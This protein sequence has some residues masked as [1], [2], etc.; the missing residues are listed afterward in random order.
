MRDDPFKQNF[1]LSWFQSW[2]QAAKPLKR[3]IFDQ[4]KMTRCYL[5]VKKKEITRRDLLSSSTSKPEEWAAWKN[6][7]FLE[8]F[9]DSQGAEPSAAPP[10]WPLSPGGWL[11]SGARSRRSSPVPGVSQNHPERTCVPSTYK[12]V[13]G[14][15]SWEKFQ[16]LLRK[17]E[18][19]P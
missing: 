16:N 18:Q 13:Q 14:N 4:N 9:E 8:K 1:S 6:R 12:E 15:F 2:K 5:I 17:V 19:S 10:R 11:G 7:W 3:G